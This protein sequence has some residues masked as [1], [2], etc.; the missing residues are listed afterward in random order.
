M[1]TIITWNALINYLL[2]FL[3]CYYTTV[4]A[5]FYRHDLIRLA[6]RFKNSERIVVEGDANDDANH[7]E[8]VLN[9]VR[10]LMLDCKDI[11]YN[12]T[13][14]PILKE[15]LIED[16]RTKVQRYPMI[17]GSQYEITMTNHIE[18]EVENRMGIRL[19][20]DELASIWR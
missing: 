12:R 1:Q 18:Q 13:N 16:I 5:L 7:S 8:T 3:I 9:Y 17:K 2:I 4:L 11:F 15:K 14:T 20:E 19:S 10:N 6:G